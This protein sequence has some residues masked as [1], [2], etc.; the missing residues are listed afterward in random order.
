MREGAKIIKLLLVEDNPD[1]I[2]MAQRALKE[3]KVICRLWIVKD[4]QAA[5]DFL[6]HRGQY[7]DF[8]AAPRPEL[9]L[10]DINL[11][12]ING[13]EVLKKIKEDPDLKRIPAVMFTISRREEDIARG[14]KY[15]CN[16][17]VQK[18]AKF[19]EFVEVVKQVGLYWGLLNVNENITN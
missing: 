1:D 17:F 7:G 9:L 11:P 19:E 3:A 2:L 5:L 12:G 10:L 14:Y 13:L 6:Q 18:P 8:A 16:S 4:G 15:G